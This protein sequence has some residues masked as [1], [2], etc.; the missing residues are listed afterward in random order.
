M[1]RTAV[2]TGDV[3]HAKRLIDAGADVGQTWGPFGASALHASTYNKHFN[4]ADMLVEHGCDVN[5]KS[6]TGKTALHYAAQGNV[7]DEVWLNSPP[8]GPDEGYVQI[9]KMLLA[10]GADVSALTTTSFSPLHIAAM[11]GFEEMVKLLL[12]NGA[13]LVQAVIPSAWLFATDKGH[14]NIAAQIAA[15]G[16][17]RELIA[18]ERVSRCEAFAMGHQERLGAVSRVRWLDAGVVRMVLEHV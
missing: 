5:F 17:R 18:A 16:P 1:F 10:K 15:E 6:S 13:N 14:H 7:L 4:M 3:L 8:D 11:N 12:A 9:A 2:F